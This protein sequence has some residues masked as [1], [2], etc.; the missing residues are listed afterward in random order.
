MRSS[1]TEDPKPLFGKL[2][3][4]LSLDKE[5]GDHAYFTSLSF[6]LEYLTKVLVAGV[7]AVVGDDV[8]RHRYSLEYRLVRADSLGTWTEVLDQALTGPA[9]QFLLTEAR[10]LIR[11]LTER[12]GPPDWRHNAVDCL[13]TAARALGV[14]HKVPHKVPLREFFHLGVRLR[15]RSRAHGAPTAAQCSEA[16][17]PLAQALDLVVERAELFQLPWVHLHRN[18]SGKYR[19]SPL[20]NESLPFDYLKRTAT[21]HYPNGVYIGLSADGRPARPLPVQ[22]VFTDANLLDILLPNGNFKNDQ[23]EVLS[24]VS[25]TDERQNGSAWTLPPNRLPRSGTEG[26]AS[27]EP[28]GDTF[29]NVPPRDR[30]Y[31]R[32]P[33]LERQIRHE[34]KEVSR[35]RIL[36]L[37]GPGGIGKTSAAI[38][39]II[40]LC[41]TDDPPY[42]TVL[43]ISARDV[44][45]LESGPKPVTQAVLTQDDISRL[46]VE[47]LEPPQR[48]DSDFSSQVYFEQ[49]LREGGAGPTL[50]VLDN[51]ETVQNPADTFR[52]LDV[53]TRSPNKVL[54]TT[55]FRDFRGD[56]WIEVGGMSDDEASA[57]VDHHARALGVSTLVSHDYK[58]ELIRESGGHP[59]VLKILL[60][61]VAK[62]GR[63]VKPQRA[64]ATADRHLGALFKRTFDALSPA[65]RRVFLLLCSW[66]AVV[67]AIAIEAVSLRPGT[68][69]FDVSRALDELRR[70][71]LVDYLEPD[72]EEVDPDAAAFVA[73]PM[74]AAIFGRGELIQHLPPPLV[75][76]RTTHL[77]GPPPRATK[78]LLPRAVRVAIEED[79][80]ILMEFGPGR[81]EDV[82]RGVL[83]RIEAL[84]Q[85]VA[86]RAD[87]TPEALEQYLPV[88]EYLA[89][90][91]PQ[92]YRRLAVLVG[93][94]GRS[95]LSLK[96]AKGYLRSFLKSA[97][98]SELLDG[99]LQLA[100][101]CAAS[102]DALSEV[103]ALCEAALL[104]TSGKEDVGR[105]AN[106]LNQRIRDL[107][108]RNIETAWSGEVRELLT[109]V[110]QKMEKELGVLSATDCSRLAWLYLN[111]GNSDRALYVARIGARREPNNEHCQNLVRNLQDL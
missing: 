94:V 50:F 79:R 98:V 91:V 63:A 83:P 48:H 45:L 17:L 11:N 57:L 53:H 111:V 44:D 110:I 88:L 60:G 84:Y 82:R 86:R 42:D 26:G 68:E 18:F 10:P 8:D 95:D 39:A 13:A 104:P 43:W 24:Y 62:E 97:D 109:R 81:T 14:D 3:N 55:R 71:S 54:I 80:K 29:A 66:R 51:F 35:H 85:T 69:R 15:N 5:D 100:D 87:D 93:E 108:E 56:Y 73:V 58:E 16:C 25:N 40:D 102:D 89:S 65:G 99:W 31:I 106:R 107:K 6:K 96:R 77:T 74:A 1:S 34:L 2:D 22:L 33:T 90:R 20:A 27:L 28:L 92:A 30:N 47:R 7:V 9:A 75:P 23:F 70:F 4:R 38:A 37:T 21:E 12:V 49:C 103:H 32:R 59:Y 78:P 76:C 64:V 105:L 72:A 46:A 61:E 36:T 19:V 101:L 41:Q 52:W 67:P